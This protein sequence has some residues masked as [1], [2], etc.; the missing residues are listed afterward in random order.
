MKKCFVV[1]RQN[2]FV[3][4]WSKML[5][6]CRD[7]NEQF[8][9]ALSHSWLSKRS[10]KEVPSTIRKDGWIIKVEWLR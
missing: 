10:P 3:G 5:P 9:D 2:E 6:L 1:F 8:E 7:L 4:I